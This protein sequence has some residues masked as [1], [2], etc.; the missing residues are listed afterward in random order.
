MLGLMRGHSYPSTL[1]FYTNEEKTR[2]PIRVQYTYML[3]ILKLPGG[4][5]LVLR[6][7]GLVPKSSILLSLGTHDSKKENPSGDD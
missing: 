3:L 7:E 2:N 5:S 4:C 6:T 1:E